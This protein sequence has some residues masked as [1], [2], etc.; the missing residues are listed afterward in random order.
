MLELNKKLEQTGEYLRANIR[1]DLDF[2]IDHFDFFRLKTQKDTELKTK[3]D[4][5]L[6][7]KIT[8]NDK[9]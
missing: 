7:R 8:A 3:I 5:N 2:V 4:S 1:Y 6:N 9:L